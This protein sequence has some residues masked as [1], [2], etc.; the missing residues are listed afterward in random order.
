MQPPLP[1]ILPVF[2]LTGLLLLP[3][4]RLPLHIF[5]PRYRNMVE[6]VLAGDRHIGMVQPVVPQ[7]DNAPGPEAPQE[8]P[9]LYPVGCASLIEEHRRL[10]DGRLLIHLLGVVRFRLGEELPLLRGYRRV[11]PDYSGFAPDPGVPP[12]GLDTAPLLE[13]LRRYGALYGV[14]IDVDRLGRL[15]SARLI[16]GLAMT[17]PFGPAEKQALL[18]AETL[19]KRHELVLALLGMGVQA[20]SHG[21]ERGPPTVN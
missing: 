7:E 11:V 1:E 13:A 20:V 17:L 19:E 14:P 2:P 3:G 16:D 10:D 8:A 18:E 21:G 12:Q 6:D 4:S 5:E 15:D 9:P